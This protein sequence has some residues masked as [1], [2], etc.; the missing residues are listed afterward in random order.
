MQV[1]KI[2][3]VTEY[4]KQGSVLDSRVAHVNLEVSG[5]EFSS[6]YEFCAYT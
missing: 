2:K 3:F 1:M 4:Q 6:L 5:H